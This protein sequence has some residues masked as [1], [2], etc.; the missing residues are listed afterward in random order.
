MGCDTGLFYY[1][2]NALPHKGYY[3]Q[4]TG[5]VIYDT[6]LL[7]VMLFPSSDN[8]RIIIVK[9]LWGQYTAYEL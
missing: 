9:R 2:A 1:Y 5:K 7:K 8:R 6:P 4:S 3:L